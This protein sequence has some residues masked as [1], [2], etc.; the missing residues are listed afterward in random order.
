VYQNQTADSAARN[1]SST[2]TDTDGHRQ[3]RSSMACGPLE[4]TENHRSVTIREAFDRSD[5]LNF[6]TGMAATGTLFT[7]S[8]WAS[9][10]KPS[11]P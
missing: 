3:G 7:G 8:T 4:F 1:S 2:A 11:H 9:I 6:N 10:S 5:N